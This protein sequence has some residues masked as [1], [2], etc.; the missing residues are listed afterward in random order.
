LEWGEVAE[1]LEE[2]EAKGTRVAALESRPPVHSW[3]LEYL[4]AFHT[5]SASRTYGMAP[6]PISLPDLIA[7]TKLHPTD[8]V[9]DFIY[10]IQKMDRL[11]LDK[12]IKD[13]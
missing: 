12:V 8:D 9:D 1:N 6:N 4:R 2:I 5:L 3:M 7:Y 10:L 11:Y 13:K